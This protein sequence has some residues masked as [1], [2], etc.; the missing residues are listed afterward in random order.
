MMSFSIRL[1]KHPA[2]AELMA[3]NQAFFDSGDINQGLGATPASLPDSD[4]S[5]TRK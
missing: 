5:G 1:L 4:A 2:Y 3:R